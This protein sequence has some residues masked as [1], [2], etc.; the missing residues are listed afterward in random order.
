MGELTSAKGIWGILVLIIM[1]MV[2]LWVF[3]MVK[4]EIPTS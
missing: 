4:K 2:G 3:R 1:V